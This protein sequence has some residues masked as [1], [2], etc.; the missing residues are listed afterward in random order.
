M[1]EEMQKT[2]EDSYWDRAVRSSFVVRA[3]ACVSCVLCSA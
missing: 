2:R 1:S 3:Y